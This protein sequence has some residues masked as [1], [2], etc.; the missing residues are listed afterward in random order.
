MTNF[1]ARRLLAFLFSI[2][3][4]AFV[5]W[6]SGAENVW[7]RLIS[8]SPWALSGILLLLVANLFL[9][10][11]RFWRVRAHF[12]INVPWKVAS[13]ACVAGHA[14]GLVVISLFGQVM[15]RQFVLQQSGVQ[16]VVDA[17]LAAYE[18]VLLA[19]VSGV[20]GVL[21]GGF[22]L[23]C[24][25]IADFFRHLPIAEVIVICGG[26]RCSACGWAV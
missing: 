17:T 14:A 22:L 11:F 5:L 25:V 20:L 9:V 26:G 8:F 19:S 16:P 23:S 13:H 2:F 18:R 6:M 24:A 10:S 7:R 21:G 4:I 12:G 3:L 1:P 15:G